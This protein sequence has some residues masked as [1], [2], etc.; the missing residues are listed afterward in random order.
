MDNAIS[1]VQRA[2]L[3][4]N[5][6]LLSRAV[7]F[8]SPLTH[9]TDHARERLYTVRT[10]YQRWLHA[11]VLM[12]PNVQVADARYV[13]AGDWVTAFY[14]LVGTQ[15]GPL[16]DYPAS[17]RR[18]SLDL[19]EVWHFDSQGCADEGHIYYDR[20]GLLDALG[21]LAPP[22]RKRS[23]TASGARARSTRHSPPRT[24]A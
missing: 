10:D 12:A 6:R 2:H 23:P 7:Q 18:F 20:M 9:I 22:S 21:H 11:T 8:V 1:A 5:A 24:P 13:G 14:R 16:D 17:G 4:W 3:A 19:C 15:D